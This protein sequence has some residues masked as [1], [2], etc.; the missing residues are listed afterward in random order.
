MK[1]NL[2]S[3]YTDV[4]SFGVTMYEIFSLGQQP[5]LKVNVTDNLTNVKIGTL[6]GDNLNDLIKAVEHGIRLPCPD[7]LALEVYRQIMYPCWNKDS[8]ERPSFSTL[9]QRIQ[10]LLQNY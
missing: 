10:E 2:F 5:N 7:G 8:H 1:E 9:C 6:Y 4:W 3:S